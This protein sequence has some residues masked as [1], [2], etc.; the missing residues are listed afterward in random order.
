[1]KRIGIYEAKTHLSQVC[2]EV[3][4]TGEACLISKNNK[5]L[6]KIVPYRAGTE[7]ASVWDTVEESRGKYGS[8]ENFDLPERLAEEDIGRSCLDDIDRETDAC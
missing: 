3:A 4:Q 6:V 8:L 7:T 5:P 1:M 2:E